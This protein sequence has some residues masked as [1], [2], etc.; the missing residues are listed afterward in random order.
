MAAEA[1]LGFA[2]GRA[3]PNIVSLKQGIWGVQPARS[4]IGSLICI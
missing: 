1:D 4:Y 3:N 2:E